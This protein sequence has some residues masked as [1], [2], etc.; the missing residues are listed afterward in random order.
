MEL[1]EQNAQTTLRLR[2]LGPPYRLSNE[3][4]EPLL[5]YRK[6]MDPLGS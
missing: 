4:L 1:L 5:K 3:Q 2:Q 6:I